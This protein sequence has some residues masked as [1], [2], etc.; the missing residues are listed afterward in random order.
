[1]KKKFILLL[2]GFLALGL[3]MAF[4]QSWVIT[5]NNNTTALSKLGTTN[6]IPVGLYTNNQQR[7]HIDE[8]G[9]VGIGNNA[10]VNILTVQSSGGTPVGSWMDGLGTNPIFDG[11]AQSQ[12]SEFVLSTASNVSGG[13]RSLI[14]G[15]RAR[16]SLATPSVVLNGDFL[17]S[18][19]ASGYDGTTFQNPA[20][21]N[22]IVD[23]VP[24]AGNVP[25]RISFETGTN[26][27][28][29]TERLQVRNNGDI[30]INQ[31][32]AFFDNST[33][34]VGIGTTAPNNTLH[35][36]KAS[37]GVVSG[38]ANAPLV[39]ENNTNSYVNVLAPVGSEKG[40]LFGEPGNAQDGGV[41]YL[42]S[43]NSL[44]FRTNGNVTRM[45]LSSAG[46]LDIAGGTLSFGSVEALSDGGTN[47]IASNSTI[48]PTTDNVRDLGTSSFRWNEVWAADGTINTSDARDKSNIRELNYGIKDIM[49]LKPARF[50]WK[51]NPEKGEKIGLIAQEL[52][53]V[54][55]EVVRDWEYKINEETG[56]REKVP[57]SRLGVAYS[58]IIPVLIRGMQEQE[59]E[60]ED[61]DQQI[62]DLKTQLNDLQNLLISKG[63]ITKNEL[64]NIPVSSTS[65]PRLSQSVPNPSSN[66]TTLSYYLPTDTKRAAIVIS[67]VNGAVLKSYPISQMGSGQ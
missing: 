54:I 59:I 36:F 43:N 5:G 29:R 65:K 61:K 32:D 1:M 49:K 8:N 4:A 40:I 9:R 62:T 46:N 20:L 6:F 3:N 23:G 39:V 33:N 53:K 7:V 2:S 47:T 30:N 14:Q 55:P 21:V 60:I 37:A 38:N 64:N 28:N 63:V 13:H 24:T 19:L 67:S 17:A 48:R 35:V 51:D 58:E 42:G 66:T 56:A 45:S 27:G 22:F 16:G 44:V 50:N 25:T 11:F 31:G 52:Q 26:V 15:R 34:R 57:S 18:I 12:S 41:I 10:P